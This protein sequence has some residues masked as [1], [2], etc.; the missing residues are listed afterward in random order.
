MTDRLAERLE[1]LGFRAMIDFVVRDDSDGR[2]PY[3]A[4]WF[5]NQ[6]QPSKEQIETAMEPP[7]ELSAIHQIHSELERVKGLMVK[8]QIL[9][10]A[11]ARALDVQALRAIETDD[12]AKLAE[13]AAEKQRLR[14]VTKLPEIDAATA[15]EHLLP[16]GVHA[17]AS[18]D[19]ASRDLLPG[20]KDRA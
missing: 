18:E 15:P 8:K 1:W 6:P 17:Q 7:A 12:K 16:I 3:L 13:V 14:D 10:E 5:S 20:Q 11:E 4:E 19:S 9:S 2:G